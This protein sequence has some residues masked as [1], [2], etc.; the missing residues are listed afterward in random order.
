MPAPFRN[1]LLFFIFSLILEDWPKCV[2]HYLKLI[3]TYPCIEFWF[4][5]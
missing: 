5:M 3:M 2:S 4:I 1:I